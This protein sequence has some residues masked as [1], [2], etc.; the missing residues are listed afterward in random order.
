MQHPSKEER[1]HNVFE[2]I[3]KNYDKMNSVISFQR[4]VA[5]RKDTMKRMNVKSGSKALDVC[6]GTAD[7]TISMAEAVG[8]NGKVVGL[9]F[10]E[11]MLSIG[12]EKVKELGANN[13]NYPW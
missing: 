10:S 2:K 4:H 3:Y 9:D 12:K 11:N 7:W 6:C 13:M 5:W 8:K 1:V